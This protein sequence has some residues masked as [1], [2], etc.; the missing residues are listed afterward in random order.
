MPALDIIAAIGIS[1]LFEIF[2]AKFRLQTGAYPLLN[3][4]FGA[5]LI[6]NL[7]WYH[8]YQ[9][10]YYNPVLGGGQV[11]QRTILVGWGE[12]LDLAGDYIRAQPDGCEKPVVAWA[13]F[14]LKP[15]V[16][17]P[18]DP[19]LPL[20]KAKVGYIVFYVSQLQRDIDRE[21]FDNLLKNQNPKHLIRLHGIDYAYIFKL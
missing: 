20:D 21:R 10:S 4:V 3:A 18:V 15:F 1:Q 16:C 5:I 11:A 12:G 13:S 19:A 7:A 6:L 9:L 2:C 14:L 8:P 17:S